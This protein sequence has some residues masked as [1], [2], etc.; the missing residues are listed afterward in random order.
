MCN[1]FRADKHNEGL[2]P[3][4]DLFD[5]HG[6]NAPI[7]FEM[8]PNTPGRFLHLDP[9]GKIIIGEGLWGMPSPARALVTKGGKP[10]SYD[11]GVTNVRNTASPHWRRWLGTQNRC[12]VPWTTFCEPD[13]V[14]GSKASI[15]FA[16]ANGQAVAWFAGV[17]DELTRQVKARD[18]AP[19]SGEFFAFLT[20]EANADVGRYHDKAMPAI[21][22][23][24]EEC[25]AWLREPWP[26]AKRFQRPLPDG[27]LKV[28]ETAGPAGALV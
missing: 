22:T 3:G 24:T 15:W 6:R 19:T 9:A 13:Q 11:P 25:E 28:V 4:Q 7:P 1:R 8:F 20:T 26:E 16:M 12:L 27:S 2:Y 5:R 18:P 21:L 23:T 14:G 17:R 10:M